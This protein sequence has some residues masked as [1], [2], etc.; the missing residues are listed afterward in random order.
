MGGDR[1]HR[2]VTDH[3]CWS[4]PSIILLGHLLWLLH[5]PT[6]HVPLSL[7]S[8]ARYGTRPGWMGSR[9]GYV[10]WSVIQRIP[11]MWDIPHSGIP[12]RCHDVTTDSTER[13]RSSSA[14]PAPPPGPPTPGVGSPA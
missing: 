6:V 5:T 8:R 10:G 7:P 2:A 14:L 4:P 11:T 1:D 9:G 3:C 13:T 12:A